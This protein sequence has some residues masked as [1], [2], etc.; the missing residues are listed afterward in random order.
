MGRLVL[1]GIITNTQESTFCE[2][3]HQSIV[4]LSGEFHGQRSL[5]GYSPWVAKELDMTEQLTHTHKHTHWHLILRHHWLHD[6]DGEMETQR[7]KW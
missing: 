3:F 6:T 7:L 5:V 4:F 2:H 1:R